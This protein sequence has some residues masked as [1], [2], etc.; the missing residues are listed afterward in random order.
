[1]MQDLLQKFQRVFME[2]QGLPPAHNRCHQICLHA[3]TE[4]VA[5]RP[6]RY[7]HAQKS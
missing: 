1:M 7:T 3:G 4:P 6:Y 5:V 2:P